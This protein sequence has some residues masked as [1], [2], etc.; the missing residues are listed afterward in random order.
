[1]A[2]KIDTNKYLLR[3]K[4]TDGKTPLRILPEFKIY[5]DFAASIVWNIKYFMVTLLVSALLLTK[6][7]KLVKF[8]KGLGLVQ[9]ASICQANWP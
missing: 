1:M 5:E 4:N 3:I 8:N 2:A 9:Q 7:Q 6:F